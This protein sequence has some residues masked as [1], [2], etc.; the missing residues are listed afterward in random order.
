MRLCTFFIVQEERRLSIVRIL[1]E[2][3]SIPLSLTMKPTNF[4]KEMPKVYFFQGLATS[5][6]YVGC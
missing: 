1:I 2:L 5:K 4:P 3:A 6:I